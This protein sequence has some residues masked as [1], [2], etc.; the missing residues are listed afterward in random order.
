MNFAPS[1]NTIHFKNI[2]N[3]CI[4]FSG[5]ADAVELES[6]LKCH[7]DG[8]DVTIER[9]VEV[10]K[11]DAAVVAAVEVVANE[12]VPVAVVAAEIGTGT[13]IL[14]FFG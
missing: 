7:R 3:L 12:T 6:V 8:R 5:I 9:E 14:S 10:A 2:F 1:I 13:F 4:L 11:V